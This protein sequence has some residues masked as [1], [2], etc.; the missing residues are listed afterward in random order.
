MIPKVKRYQRAGI[1]PA[2]RWVKFNNENALR[3]MTTGGRK[4]YMRRK[5]EGTGSKNRLP[6]QKL[7]VL[8]IIY[9]IAQSI[10]I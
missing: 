2:G 10:F 9:S 6:F 1:P 5:N 4:R 3:N 8:T 7:T